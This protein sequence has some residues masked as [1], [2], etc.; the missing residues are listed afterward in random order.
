MKYCNS[1]EQLKP[2]SE[3][4][5][6]K[7][8]L[9]GCAN[10]CKICTL[11]KNA[12]RRAE[13]PE[14]HLEKRRAHAK[15]YYPIAYNKYKKLLQFDQGARLRRRLAL[16][17]WNRLKKFMS[18]TK[19]YTR[20]SGNPDYFYWTTKQLAEHLESLFKEGMTWENYG[21]ASGER[22]TWQID[23]K[24]PCSSFNFNY[25]EEVRECWKLENLQPLWASD[26]I[27]KGKKIN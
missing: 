12:K 10:Y 22:K 6:S 19:S 3:F 23:H 9:T 4:H 18:G 20:P 5:K 25:L 24:K 26:N 16:L 21:A 27:K 1:C 11:E 13:N 8:T 14:L 17:V 2:F 15:K 7:A